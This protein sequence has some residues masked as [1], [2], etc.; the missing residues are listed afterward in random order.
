M[1][2]FRGLFLLAVFCF[3]VGASGA[4]YIWMGASAV[5]SEQFTHHYEMKLYRWNNETRPFYMTDE[6]E[7]SFGWFNSLMYVGMFSAFGVLIAM[8][9]IGVA[10]KNRPD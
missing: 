2:I 6:Q 1:Q 8:K 3:L 7:R 5:P 9:V 4:V 10:G